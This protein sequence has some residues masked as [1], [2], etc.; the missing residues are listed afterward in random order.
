MPTEALELCYPDEGGKRQ[1]S[2][3][4]VN[5]HVVGTMNIADRSPALVDALRRRFAF[6]RRRASARASYV[7]VNQRH[8][9]TAAAPQ[10]GFPTRSIRFLVE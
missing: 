7:F 4:P 2:T 8:S 5:L 3:S 6:I 9:A 1:P 10:S